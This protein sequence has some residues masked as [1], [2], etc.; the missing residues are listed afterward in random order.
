MKKPIKIFFAFL[1]LLNLLHF[2]FNSSNDDDNNE[3]PE[4]HDNTYVMND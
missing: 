2:V 4:I 3:T 1:L